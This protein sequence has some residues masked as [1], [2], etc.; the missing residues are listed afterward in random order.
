MSHKT[1]PPHQHHFN[2][3]HGPFYEMVFA[4]AVA[5]MT[6]K[7]TMTQLETASVSARLIRVAHD[8]AMQAVQYEGNGH[9]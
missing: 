7:L 3:P 5:G 9:T 4:A 2:S 1:T 8:V 6:T